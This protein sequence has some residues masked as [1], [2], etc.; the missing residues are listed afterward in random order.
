[1]NLGLLS[2]PAQSYLGMPLGT[3]L[4]NAVGKM[5]ARFTEAKAYYQT[6]LAP[7]LKEAAGITGGK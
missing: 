2:N 3:S 7:R 5:N 1:V 6:K 4:K